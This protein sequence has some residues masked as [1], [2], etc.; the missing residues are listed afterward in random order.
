MS[1]LLIR[2]VRIFTGDKIIPNGSVLV[3]DGKIHQLSESQLNPLDDSTQVFSKPGHTLIPGLVDAH[4]HADKGNPLAL[5]QALRFGVTTVC[6][7]HNESGNVIKLRRQASQDTDSADFKSCSYSATIDKGWPEAVITAH[8]KS[9][10]T[11]AEIS[12][13]PKLTSDED[14]KKYMQERIKEKVDYIKLMHESGTAMGLQLPRPPIELQK[15][16]IDAA[17]AN[18]LVAVAHATCLKDTIEILGAGIDGLTH[19]FCDQPP[20]EEVIDAYRKNNAYCNPTLVAIGSLTTE[21]QEHQE[22]FAHD[23]RV[24]SLI[25]KAQIDNMCRCMGMAKDKGQL[26]NAYE[27]VRQLKAAG[28]DIVCGSDAAG[29]AL[30]TA[31][32]LT[33]HHEL[34]LFVK[35][36]GFTPKEALRAATVLPAERL[37]LKDRGRIAPGLNADLVLIEGDP[38]KEINHTLD[39]RGVWRNGVLCSAYTGKIF[40]K[41][42]IKVVAH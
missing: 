20:N 24:E 21:G 1:S 38:T 34:S 40:A 15:I 33:V 2:D 26:E 8:D 10:E 9:E 27:S 18:G 25:G 29:P 31:W 16:V 37:K 30:G 19:T 28:I 41:C 36:C 42:I 32:G 39:L 17:H 11:A 35:E 12:T 13:W 4:I 3:S 7:M 5:T 22:R 14:V 23:P 6:D